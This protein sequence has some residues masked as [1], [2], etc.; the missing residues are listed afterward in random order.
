MLE[1]I[2]PRNIDE[3]RKLIFCERILKV[4]K[5]NLVD[6]EKA[7]ITN[8]E[9]ITKNYKDPVI[10]VALEKA[11][12]DAESYLKT[13]GWNFTVCIAGDNLFISFTM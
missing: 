11:A 5:E 6:N 13:T 8:L 2:T 3:V 10:R 7:S 12:K 1:P 4:C 9:D